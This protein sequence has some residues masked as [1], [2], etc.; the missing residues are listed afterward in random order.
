[1]SGLEGVLDA[2]NLFPRIPMGGAYQHIQ[3]ITLATH[4]PWL[5]KERRCK[6][7]AGKVWTWNAYMQDIPSNMKYAA[8]SGPVFKLLNMMRRRQ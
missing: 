7:T 5:I 2:E 4:W 6:R 1:M 3:R 8:R